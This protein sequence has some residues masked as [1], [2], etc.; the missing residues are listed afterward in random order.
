MR[1]SSEERR[2]ELVPAFP[3]YH[4]AVILTW[5]KNVSTLPSMSQTE[6]K[7]KK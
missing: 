1:R 2:G 7:V 4:G 3:N 5:E 6:H